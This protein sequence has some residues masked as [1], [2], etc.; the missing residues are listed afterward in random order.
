[1][2]RSWMEFL[3][4]YLTHDKKSIL[5]LESIILLYLPVGDNFAM[6]FL[7]FTVPTAL[8]ERELY[9]LPVAVVVYLRSCVRANAGVHEPAGVAPAHH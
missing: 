7:R 9:T 8:I 4:L 3:E 5:L 2:P 1:M 6:P